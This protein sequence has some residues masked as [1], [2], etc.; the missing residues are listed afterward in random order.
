M[1]IT[2]T[3]YVTLRSRVS[4][5]LGSDRSHLRALRCTAGLQSTAQLTTTPFVRSASR[6]AV[7]EDPSIAPQILAAVRQPVYVTY[8]HHIYT[9]TGCRITHRGQHLLPSL[10]HRPHRGQQARRVDH[11]A[12]DRWPVQPQGHYDAPG[13]R[14]SNTLHGCD[15]VALLLQDGEVAVDAL[16]GGEL[17]R[18]VGG[19]ADVHQQHLPATPRVHLLLHPHTLTYSTLH[20]LFHIRLHT[21]IL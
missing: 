17:A 1:C 5:R 13:P 14:R 16:Q 6:A 9:L 3:C 15:A 12:I 2:H 18:D 8:I 4:A 11:R 21:N 19:H 20:N 10:P 7:R